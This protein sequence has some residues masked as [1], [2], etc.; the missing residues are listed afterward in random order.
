[1]ISDERKTMSHGICQSVPYTEDVDW[2]CDLGYEDFQDN[3]GDVIPCYS[4]MSYKE[5]L[6]RLL[7][8]YD[9]YERLQLGYKT[10]VDVWFAVKDI[11]QRM[12]TYLKEIQSSLDTLVDVVQIESDLSNFLIENT[13]VIKT[14][15]YIASKYVQYIDSR[16]PR[17][18]SQKMRNIYNHMKA[19]LGRNYF[20]ESL[21]RILQE[22]YLAIFKRHWLVRHSHSMGKTMDALGCTLEY[23][24]ALDRFQKDLIILDSTV[25]KALV[26]LEYW[27]VENGHQDHKEMEYHLE[28]INKESNLLE[29][30]RNAS[31]LSTNYPNHASNKLLQGYCSNMQSYS[32]ME[33]T[34]SCDHVQ[35]LQV[36]ESITCKQTGYEIYTNFLGVV[37]YAIV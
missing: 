21:R 19:N 33:L 5:D 8:E 4:F 16:D 23:H 14:A 6:Q 2:L 25:A 11:G 32:G 3:N 1:M 26:L 29:H 9:S 28:D 30:W 13:K 34:L 37:K 7:Q 35:A 22:N 10:S 15:Q 24:K 31:C 17:R 18:K 27:M 36:I 12:N 20:L